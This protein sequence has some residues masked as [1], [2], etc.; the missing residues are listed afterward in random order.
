M[1]EEIKAIEKN[2]TWDLVDL[3]TK[4]NTYWVKWVYKTKFNEKRKIGKLKV[5]LVAKGLVHNLV[6]I[7]ERCSL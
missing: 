1:D 3:S 6:L 5:R 2:Q 4:K 7:T